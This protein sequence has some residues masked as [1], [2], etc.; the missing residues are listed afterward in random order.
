MR[1]KRG[2]GKCWTFSNKDPLAEAA[3]SDDLNHIYR[4]SLASSS[5]NNRLNFPP[6]STQG[7]TPPLIE[8][9]TSQCPPITTRTNQWAM[10]TI[11][12]ETGRVPSWLHVSADYVKSTTN[13]NAITV[14]EN[15]R[16]SFPKPPALN[17]N[18]IWREQI[19]NSSANISGECFEECVRSVMPVKTSQALSYNLKFFFHL[20]LLCEKSS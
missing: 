11:T 9:R 19:Y 5:P 18:F 14:L 16:W 8:H 6:I 20:N 10:Q 2:A 12:T 15:G 13:R 17:L 4:L 1:K 7:L 3:R